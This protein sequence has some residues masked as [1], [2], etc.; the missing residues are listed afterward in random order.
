[1]VPLAEHFREI[2][3]DKNSVPAAG[4]QRGRWSRC[5]SIRTLERCVSLSIL[6]NGLCCQ[7]NGCVI[8]AEHLHFEHSLFK[9]VCAA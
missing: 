6:P 1:M 2:C 4:F 8:L 9:Q 7:V 3:A 5:N